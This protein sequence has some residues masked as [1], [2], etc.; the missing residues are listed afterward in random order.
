MAATMRDMMIG[1][2]KD[3]KEEARAIEDLRRAGFTGNQIEV[4]DHDK[5][6][7]ADET[8]GRALRDRGIP[9]SEA[10]FYQDEFRSGANLVTVR[11]GSRQ[12]EAE[13]ILRRHGAR[14]RP[15]AIP[16]A[17]TAPLPPRAEAACTTPAR[18]K[19]LP[20]T[21]E[22]ATAPLPPR[23]AEATRAVPIREEKL[24]ARKE[25]VPAGEV[26]VKKDVETEHKTMN[27]PVTKEEVFVERRPVPNEPAARGPI[28]ASEE[29][30]IPVTEERVEVEK[31]PVV[32]EEI[33]V[34]KHPVQE[35]KT[36]EGT[37][38]K[39]VAKV[40]RKGDVDAGPRV[41]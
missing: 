29:V 36:V 26:V 37:V 27:V 28:R 41:P 17:A 2:F 7:L 39:E 19:G 1:S 8:V 38:R 15:A 5:D 33:V 10:R 14:F 32:K 25:T 21:R 40:E 35:N 4:A 30:R 34:G 11:A 31:R 24:Q 23:G 9:E 3:T 12:A 13:A 20:A 22:A 16:P 6:R 18:E